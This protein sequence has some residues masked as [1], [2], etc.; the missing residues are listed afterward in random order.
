VVEVAR[1]L[2]GLV[3]VGDRL[4]AT[5]TDPTLL[6]LEMTESVVID[7][8]ARAGLVLADLKELGGRLALDDF[9]A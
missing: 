3:R 5:G 9:G 7:D 4:A 6:I 1:R 2:R 8:S